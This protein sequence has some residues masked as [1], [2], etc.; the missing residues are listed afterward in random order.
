[1]A[2]LVKEPGVQPIAQFT[3]P[4]RG[5]W[6]SIAINNVPMDAVYASH[7][8]FLREGKLSERP[9][10]PLISGSDFTTPVIG[11]VMVV[12]PME[13]RM[14]AVT[15][16]IFYERGE[17]DSQW[18]G[19][20]PFEGNFSFTPDDR[21]MV[22]IAYMETTGTAVAIIAAQQRPL[23][24]WNALTHSITVMT[25]ASGS[26]PIPYAKSVYRHIHCSG[27]RYLKSTITILLLITR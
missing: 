14:L 6:N 9:G 8:V 16:N 13:K 10:L 26:T 20:A 12:T 2:S 17:Y 18:S 24:Q 11:G 5:T 27:Q 1:M 23:K 19:T 4:I 21:T 25:P 15:K 7:N 22:D 3:V